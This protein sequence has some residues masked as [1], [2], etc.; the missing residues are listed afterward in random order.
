MRLAEIR[1]ADRSFIYYLALEPKYLGVNR[2]FATLERTHNYGICQIK[3]QKDK[4]QAQAQSNDKS[5]QQQDKTYCVRFSVNTPFFFFPNSISVKSEKDEYQDPHPFVFLPK[6]TER[7]FEVAIFGVVDPNLSEQVGVLNFSWLN[8]NAKLKSVVSAEDPAEALR[9]QLDYFDAWYAQQPSQSP[10]Q[11]R[12]DDQ[13][14]HFAGLKVLLAQ[15]SPQRARTLATRMPE[16]QVVVAAADPEQATGSI[17]QSIN[18][19]PEIGA[20]A[21]I[22]VPRPAFDTQKRKVAV[23]LPGITV[24]QKNS[25]WRL[26]SK[27]TNPEW[28]EEAEARAD[29]SQSKDELKKRVEAHLSECLSQ[30]ANKAAKYS[31]QLKWMTLCAMRQRTGADVA[32]IQKRDFFFDDLQKVHNDTNEFQRVLDRVI[33]K[34][35][36][37][38]LLYVPGAALKKALAQSRKYDAEDANFL[39][40]ADERM[41]GLEYVGIDKIAG[42]YVINE[43]PIEDKKIYSIAISDYIGAGDTGYPDL[44]STALDAK[45]YPTEFPSRLESISSVVCRRLF[46]DDKGDPPCLPKLERRGYLDESNAQP[47]IAASGGGVGSKL[48]ALV[49]FRWPSKTSIPIGLRQAAQEN[50]QRHPIWTLSLRNFSVGFNGLTKNLSDADI[51]AKFAGIPTPGVTAKKNSSINAQLDT[52]LSRTSHTNEFFA[53]FGADYKETSTGDVAPQIVQNNNRAT[54]DAGVIR[55]LRGGRSQTRMGLASYLHT[56]APLQ[57]PFSTFA[58]SG[59][60]KLKITQDRNFLILPRVGL[61]WQHRANSF[62]GG[63]QVGRELNAF[64]GYRLVTQGKT[65]GCLPSSGETFAGCVNGLIKAGTVTKDSVASA[66]LDSRSRAGALFPD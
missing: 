44:A 38:T 35:D 63:I 27:Q 65:A 60:N 34:G 6:S 18:W 16:F 9:E 29:N 22:A 2:H 53:A 32:L 43:T 12:A 17:T 26:E 19:T 52:R 20:A 66:I 7:P 46:S 49:P 25:E 64:D 21:F 36:L 59:Q 5:K 50:A 37:L 30:K 14:P 58:L 54:A 33:W 24:S 57:K 45:R 11:R 28:V 47:V 61:R 1:V 42:E 4:T 40:L 15:M 23:D 10:N 51:A 39:S 55:S 3:D 31:E 41:R 48:L 56:E 8:Q 62:E 13:I